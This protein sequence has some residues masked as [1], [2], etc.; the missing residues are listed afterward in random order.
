MLSQGTAFR[1]RCRH[2]TPGHAPPRNSMESNQVRCQTATLGST[3]FHNM[4]LDA[5]WFRLRFFNH[6][7]AFTQSHRGF[8]AVLPKIRVRFLLGRPKNPFVPRNCEK[9]ARFLSGDLCSKQAS[10]KHFS[11]ARHCYSGISS[12]RSLLTAL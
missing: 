1:L 9:G 8:S 3:D 11:T 6:H 7:Q 5:D 4:H 12:A 2:E 10:T